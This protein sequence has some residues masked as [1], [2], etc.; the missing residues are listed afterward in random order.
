VTLRILLWRGGESTKPR[1]RRAGIHMPEDSNVK[2]HKVIDAE[3]L[4]EW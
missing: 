3:C 2:Q 1:G 4:T